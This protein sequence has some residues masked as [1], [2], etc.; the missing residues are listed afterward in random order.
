MKAYREHHF[1]KDSFYTTIF[2]V[3]GKAVGYL[4]PFFIAA[5]FGVNENIDVFFYSYGVMFFLTMIF[6]NSV[7]NIIVPIVSDHKHNYSNEKLEYLIGRLMILILGGL[8]FVLIITFLLSKKIFSVITNFSSYQINILNIYF[9]EFIPFTF[10]LCS[11]SFLNGILNAYK[12]FWV[13]ALSP[14]VRAVVCI[15]IIYI[16]KNDCGVHSII[17]GYNIGELSRL[18]LLILYIVHRKLFKF[19]FDFKFDKEIIDVFIRVSFLM[20]S[21][22]IVGMNPLVDNSFASWLPVGSISLLEYTNKL[23]AIPYNFITFGFL[24]VFL[25]H[26]SDDLYKYGFE[27]FK[28]NFYNY[29]RPILAGVSTITLVL[30][31]LSK[32]IVNLCFGIG[33]RIPMEALRS[34]DILY[35]ISMIGF[36]PYIIIQ[37]FVRGFLALKATRY[38][39][40]VS[41]IK[42]ILNILL[43]AY[44]VRKF[45][46][47]GIMLA[48]TILNYILLI[49]VYVF[50][51]NLSSVNKL[52]SSL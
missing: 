32:Y 39:L 30:I 28:K 14:A 36:I 51:K 38:L 21:T 24:T 7:E 46:I 13:P 35:I 49:V 31:F 2:T 40:Y 18:L 27:R 26:L 12:K 9:L 10:F 52:K 16:L 1:I 29:L 43:D 6:S 41:I 22:L 33:G 5:W 17:I 8:A 45:G 23:V 3:I 48:S 50:F 25:S 42:F 4:I 47:N 11:S 20:I 34:I 44:L 19:R 37:V 15:I